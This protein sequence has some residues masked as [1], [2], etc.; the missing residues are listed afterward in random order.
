[1]IKGIFHVGISTPDLGQ[2]VEFYR[3]LLGFK[4]MRKF[5]WPKGI[6]IADTIT[7][8]KDSAASVVTLEL[9][10]TQIEL[11]QFESPEPRPSEPEL[12]VCDHGLTH[13][14][15]RV[16]DLHCEYER[17]KNAGMRFHCEPQDMGLTWVTYG[18]DPDGNVVELL[19]HK[20]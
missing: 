17:L 2:L 6:D 9:G 13:I 7:G 3:D 11:F 15:L 12:R 18:R 16:K 10:E 5:S 20:E 8:L 19:E 4:V 14:C 1:M